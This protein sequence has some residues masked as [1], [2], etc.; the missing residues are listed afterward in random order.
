MRFEVKLFFLLTLPIPVLCA[1]G[2]ALNTCPTH[3]GD[4]SEF[5]SHSTVCTAS[6]HYIYCICLKHFFSAGKDSL[7][8]LNA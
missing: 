2:W 7:P 1:S 6:S 4:C 5:L 8:E 3:G